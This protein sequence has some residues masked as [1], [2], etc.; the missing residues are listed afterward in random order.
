MAPM[1]TS[2]VLHAMCVL[3]AIHIIIF[4]AIPQAF[5]IN[6]VTTITITVNVFIVAKRES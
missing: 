2:M 6:V 4:F 3:Q 1:P 5:V